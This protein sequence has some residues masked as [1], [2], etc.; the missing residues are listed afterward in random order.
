MSD[1]PYMPLWVSKYDAKTKH[2]SLEEDGAYLRLLRL[3]WAT[4]G[5]TI[6]ANREWVRRQMRVD[7]VTFDRV[8][9]VVLDEFFKVRRGRYVNDK[10]CEI[11]ASQLEKSGKASAKAS[12]AGKASALKKKE[13]RS[14]PSVLEVNLEPTHPEP[15]PEPKPEPQP[16]EVSRV[17]F[18]RGELSEVSESNLDELEASCRKWANGSLANRAGPLILGPVIRLLKPISGEPCTLDDVRN[19]ITKAAA[20]LHKRGQQ[21]SS[22]GYF[23]KPIIA[24]RDQRLTPLP[25]PEIHHERAGQGQSGRPANGRGNLRAGAGRE[26]GT[27][28]LDAAWGR[29]FGDDQ[30]PADISDE[31]IDGR[32]YR[33]A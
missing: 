29:L 23:E 31:P 8:V 26:H 9:Q 5:R 16:E 15:K 22:L 24:E 6:P 3:C 2:L 12:K 18:A 1:L 32:A 17:V 20:S 14:T 27:A 13:K 21:V 33:L 7:D 28:P 11:F 10:L 4:P 30:A 25:E 19:G